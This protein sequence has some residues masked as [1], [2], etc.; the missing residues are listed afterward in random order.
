[1]I[2]PRVGAI[3]V[4]CTECDHLSRRPAFPVPVMRCLMM[5]GRDIGETTE[6]P[7]WCPY[8]EDAL[9]NAF[10]AAVGQVALEMEGTDGQNEQTCAANGARPAGQ[11]TLERGA[12]GQSGVRDPR[13]TARA[14]RVQVRTAD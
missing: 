6:T 5:G 9:A 13:V 1:M 7:H 4:H 14:G 3:R 10:L 8:R 11:G 12:A 2:G